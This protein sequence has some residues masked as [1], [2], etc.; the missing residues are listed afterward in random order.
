M[1]EG[2]KEDWR[3]KRREGGRKDRFIMIYAG[4]RKGL[5]EKRGR[6][7]KGEENR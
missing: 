6:D 2:R 4:T 5:K 1:K 3:S 7:E